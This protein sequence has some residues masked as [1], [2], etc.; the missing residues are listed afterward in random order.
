LWREEALVDEAEALA[1]R[2]APLIERTEA[3]DVID[4]VAG[5]LLALLALD[6]CRRSPRA[7]ELARR[8]GERL[9]AGAVPQVR[10]LGWR[11]SGGRALAGLSHGASGGAWALLELARV[12]GEERWREAAR[13]ALEYERVLFRPEA[14]TWLDLRFTPDRGPD[15]EARRDDAYCGWCNGA[16]GIGLAR[17]R[18]AGLLE[19]PAL[20]REAEVALETTLSVGFG[21]NHSLCHGD[22]GNLELLLQAGLHLDGE[23]WLPRARAVAAGVLDSMRE[24]G[25]VCGVPTGVETPGLMTGI[26]GIGYGCLRLAAP[27]R[28]PSVLLLEAPGAR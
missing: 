8:C 5:C 6:G 16:A 3:L 26:T 28:V 13:Q 2:L 10:G 23:R 1:G 14:G 15:G 7:V 21:H 11:G 22:W 19:E 24:R 27:R 9:L 25:W 17:V 20:R 4:G 18:M 12:T